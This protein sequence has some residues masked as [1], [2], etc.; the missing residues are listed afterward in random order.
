MKHKE[1]NTNGL[2]I[3]INDVKGYSQAQEAWRF[4]NNANV[5][6]ESL[7]NPI[8]EKGL[9]SIEKECKE[10]L[11]VS[12]DWS[13]INYRNHTAKIDCIETK[14]SNSTKA[15]SKGYDLQSSLGISD[16]TGE[17]ITP[18]VHNLKTKD[19]VFSTYNEK[20]DMKETHLSELSKR[21]PYINNKLN[22][23]KKK[24]HIIDREADSVGFLRA[25]TEDDFY[26][27]RAVDER[28]VEYN[29]EKIN[30]KNLSKKIA[31]GEYVKNI[32][33]KKKS[34]KIYVNSVKVQIT[35]D[36][37]VKEIDENGKEKRKRVKGRA[38]DVRFVVERLVDIDNNV[39]ATWLLL[40]NLKNDVDDKTIGLWYYY[41]WNIETYFKL[42]KSSGFNLEKW[43]QETAEAI[44]KRLLIASFACLLVWQI[45]HSNHKNIIEIKEFLVKLSGRLIARGKVSTSPALLA[46]IWSF[47]STMDILELYDIEKLL[48]MKK[49]LNEFLGMDF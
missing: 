15:I 19:K 11:L 47:F 38:L 46:G 21:I 14:R 45:E 27:I 7:N 13:L 29:G 34:V 37:Y 5:D 24:V 3:L 41:R 2:S 35:R 25:L 9:E 42:L 32:K 49:E 23:K 31:L 16:I 30:Q 20:I 1:N 10:Y 43:Q 48:S 8:M 44:F 4:Y 18:L 33:Y 22:I 40:T 28:L 12:H 26:I 6:I 39:V 36:A 17:P